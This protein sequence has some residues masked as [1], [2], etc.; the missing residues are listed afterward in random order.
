MPN[1]LR[2]VVVVFKTHFDL[3]FTG[4]PEEVMKAYTGPMFD[5]VM[6]TM[7]ARPTSRRTCAMRGRCPRGLSAICCTTRRCLRRR[8]ERRA[9][10]WKTGGC[11]GTCGLSRRTQLFAGWRTWCGGCTFHARFPRSSGGGPRARS[12]PTCRGIHGYYRRYCGRRSEIPASGVQ[13]WE[14]LAAC[15]ALLLVGGA[16][17]SAPAHVLLARSLWHVPVA[18]ARLG[19]RYV[20]FTAADV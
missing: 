15:A 1:S 16:G 20:D 18:A 3:G 7:E 9:S 6:R 11:T 2:K 14:P 19:V 13:S 10:W 12:R 5:A 8:V 17:R 4:L